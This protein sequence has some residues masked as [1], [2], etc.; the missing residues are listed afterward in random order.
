MA[1]FSHQSFKGYWAHPLDAKNKRTENVNNVLRVQTDMAVVISPEGPPLHSPWGEE[2]TSVFTDTRI[3]KFCS[4][5]SG[6]ISWTRIPTT[7]FTA[8]CSAYTKGGNQVRPEEGGSVHTDNAGATTPSHE[9]RV[10]TG[11]RQV[12]GK[13]RRHELCRVASVYSGNQKVS[14]VRCV[15]NKKKKTEPASQKA[16]VSTAAFRSQIL[17][18]TS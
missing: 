14:V 16:L 11:T 1:C 7:P 15:L 6:F 17:E 12:L 10:L 9:E 18:S 4:I 3:R 13:I 5:I 8:H 2:P